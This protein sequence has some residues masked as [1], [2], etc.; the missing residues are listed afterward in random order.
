MVS[1]FETTAPDTTAPDTAAPGTAAPSPAAGDT[2]AIA[3][4]GLACRLPGAPDPRTFW[5]NL[6][7]GRESI[8]D[9][10]ADRWDVTAY[11]DADR[12]A[13]GRTNSR[14]AGHLE[15]VDRFDTGFF[16]IS[17]REAAAMDPQQR[18]I[19]ELSWEA[20]EDG[21]IVPTD[22]RGSRTGVFVGAIW[23]DYATLL[24]RHGT[25]AI[26]R[27]T[28]TGLHRSIIA[29]RVSYTLGLHGPSMAV[30]AAQSSSL[31]SVHMACQ[32]LRNGES[33]LAL[34]GGVNLNLVPE[35]TVGAA[36][37]GGLSPDGRCHTFDARANGYVRGEGAGLV[38]LK[39]LAQA[40][41]D[42][43]RVHCVIRGSAVNN[44]G[45]TNG[46]TVPSRR[47]QEKVLRRALARAGVTGRDVQYVEL[48][49][50][51][52]PLGDPIE[53]AALGAAV[54]ADH[55]DGP[56]LAVGSVKTNVGHLEGAAGI[57]GLI[58]TV[59]SI[60][61][62]RLPPSLNFETP[63]PDIPLDR[64][65][66]RVQTELGDWPSPER[67][68]IAGVSS[69]G[70]GGTNCHVV[71]AEAPEGEPASYG[72]G[73]S[74]ESGDSGGPTALVL[75]ARTE[76]A[77][78]EQAGRVRALLDERPGV[79]VRDVAWSL[80]ASR[81][82]FGRRAVVA[83]ADRAELVAGLDAFA[84]GG[85]GAGVAGSAGGRLAFLFTGQGSQRVGMGRG[86]YA[87][88]PVFAAAFD[89]V[90]AAFDGLLDVPL[91][92]AVDGELVHETGVTQPGL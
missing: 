48:H 21:R 4:I 84:A 75:S 40:L 54:G 87:S 47:A 56:A 25:D 32:S 30:D 83:G 38:L 9:V 16:G 86:L 24:H 66:L 29:N 34:A 89:E 81:A 61:H 8:T 22:L 36:K 58:K 52:T 7:E 41:A 33:N 57:T 46:L 11:Y 19:L 77:L 63:N 62:R 13:P 45:A 65:R 55:E 5:Q 90:V 80:V 74:G 35:S 73:E 72:T 6:V 23:D 59:L 69:F 2:A 53:A 67:P 88:F 37:F 26:G 27:H 79:R 64:L 68:L 20:L 1:E 17:P 15:N 51:G 78:R 18:L 49:G 28:I 85:A 42:G 76:G 31:V 50:T 14:R 92:E 60:K 12:D 44:D 39:P 10:P 70:M 3:V 43:D 71:L 91:V 82:R